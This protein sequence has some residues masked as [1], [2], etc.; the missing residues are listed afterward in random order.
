LGVHA[1][2]TLKDQRS[3]VD[4]LVKRYLSRPDIALPAEPKDMDI[5]HDHSHA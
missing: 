3:A 5:L 2:P 1:D 4:E